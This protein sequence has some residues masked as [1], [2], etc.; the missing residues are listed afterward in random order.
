M[1]L[2][3]LCLIGLLI[4]IPTVAFDAQQEDEKERGV[5][6]VEEAVSALDF[7]TYHALIIGINE[8]SLWPRLD[9]AEQDASDI[10]QIL[11]TRYGF[12]SDRVT[13]LSGANATRSKILSGLRGKLESLAEDDNLLVY[14]AGHGQLD[15][16]TENGYWIPVEGGLYDESGW[17]AF[18]NIQTLL[19]GRGVKAKSVM[20]LTD[21]CYGGA[22]ARSGPTPGHRGPTDEDY[23]QYEQRLSKLAKKRSRQIIASGGYEQVPDRSVFAEL[24]KQ[25]LKENTYP[26]IDLEYLFFG[27]VYPQLKF[28]GQQEPALTRLVSG[29][30]EDGQF[31]LLQNTAG[32]Q[33][34]PPPQP[35]PE[36][37]NQEASEPTPQP[38]PKAVLTVRSNV[39]DDMVYIDGQAK[40]STRLDLELEPG[41]H[42]VF[43]EKEG[44][45]PY[46][47][48][49]ELVSG[50]NLTVQAQLK[51]IT[52]KVAAAPVIDSFEADPSHIPRGQSAMLHWRTQHAEAVEIAGIGRVP[53]SGSM[54]IEPGET[55]TYVLIATNEQGLTAERETQITVA[56]EAPRIVSFRASPTSISQGASST[57]SWQTENAQAVH[58][59]GIGRVELTG[60]MR[61]HPSETA[62]YDLIAENEQ[63]VNI[64]KT[65]TVAVVS[66]LPRILSFQVD[67]PTVNM[68]ETAKLRWQVSD[69]TEV[70]INGKSV[71][72]S[73]SMAVKPRKSSTYVL[74]AKNR[75]GATVAE[76][77]R[78]R[79]VVP[80]PEIVRF[81]ATSPIAEG[82]STTL[83]WRTVNTEQV[84]ISGIG[85]VSSSGTQR[86]A[87]NTTTT[88]TL[89][90]KNRDGSQVRQKATVNVKPKIGKL[91]VP[92]NPKIARSAVKVYPNPE[93][94]CYDQVQGKIA[95]EYKGSKRWAKGNLQRL[96]RGTSNGNQPA[97]CFDRVMHGGI[98][99]GGGTRWRGENAIDLCEGTN[100][101]SK[102]INCFQNQ[103][104]TGA[105]WQSA[106][107]ACQTR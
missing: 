31:V 81:E 74:T 21:S 80:G 41:P 104:R 52:P 35:I 77:Q 39:Y 32:A 23:Q 14:Y 49:V 73:D 59:S 10:R 56:I 3:R 103:I 93:K 4:V 78:I 50:E 29:P 94:V 95:W 91:A 46:E 19:T 63:G 22:L 96:C 13:Y 6:P 45:Q 76:E 30:E 72:P 55:M 85:R 99:Y 1:Q 26:M 83:T 9:F 75:E 24:L 44:Y 48:Q 106:I 57:L 61:V 18:S 90:A 82:S 101:A 36:T 54:P 47:Q 88:Y 87:P 8:Y 20:V 69:A 38:E 5:T 64:E 34:T 89:T 17:I 84:E 27:K 65:L 60:S 42:A 2:G 107:R 98:N 33:F 66:S 58:I 62:T 28:I 40:G 16:L 68:G 100:N 7:G 11:I 25:A 51:P 102:T 70:S 43:V 15:P 79:V 105:Q 86:V 67:R 97:K 92:M 53:L 71:R 37:T 12:A